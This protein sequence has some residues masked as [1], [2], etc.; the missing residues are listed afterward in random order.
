MASDEKI[1]ASASN[2]ASKAPRSVPDNIDELWDDL[3]DTIPEIEPEVN[4]PKTL[5]RRISDCFWYCDSSVFMIIFG[6]FP[7]MLGTVIAEPY[8]ER[9]A[10]PPYATF[11]GNITKSIYL[12]AN[13]TYTLYTESKYDHTH[14]SIVDSKGNNLPA[15]T[16]EPNEHD[17][18]IEYYY[19]FGQVHPTK[20]GTYKFFCTEQNESKY[21]SFI[22]AETT[23]FP[24][25]NNISS[26]ICYNRV[27]VFYASTIALPGLLLISAGTIN[28]IFRGL[29][30]AARSR[31]YKRSLQG[32]V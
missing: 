25:L 9:A 20:S 31:A 5:W 14:C 6:L 32:T 27:I 11:E 29:R 12:E 30:N 13:K 28:L 15:E 1:D 26:E 23:T 21:Q 4:E 17:S 8:F 3:M 10:I 24:R 22:I 19:D 2:A 16:W 7:L 18:F